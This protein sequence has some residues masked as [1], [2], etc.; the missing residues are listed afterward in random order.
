MFDLP[1]S[2]QRAGPTG[3]STPG[4]RLCKTRYNTTAPLYG[5]SL[6][7]G[8]PVTIVQK[9]PDLLQQV[10]FEVCE[11]VQHTCLLLKAIYG[12]VLLLI[13]SLS[14]PMQFSRVWRRARWVRPNLRSLFV[15]GYP[16]RTG[17][18][19]RPRLRPRRKRLR[20]SSKVRPPYW[21]TGIL[22]VWSPPRFKLISLYIYSCEKNK[23]KQ[24]KTIFF[25]EKTICD[26]SF[27][28]Y[29]DSATVVNQP[30]RRIIPDFLFI[31]PRTSQTNRRT[32]QFKRVLQ[33]LI[34]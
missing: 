28:C 3:C 7:S 24:T 2:Q 27:L 17:N 14:S 25:Q 1:Q 16:A 34:Y 22:L 26:G 23:Q 33:F 18:A 8:Q 20:L 4:G 11:W 21:T 29:D 32:I 13:R 12:W 10:I 15:S 5:V 30:S 6:T 19:D 9:F 31:I